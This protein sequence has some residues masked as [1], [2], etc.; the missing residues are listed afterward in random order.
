MNNNSFDFSYSY[1]QK[2]LFIIKTNFDQYL[3][4]QAPIVFRKQHNKPTIF[5]RH[6]ID[7]DLEKALVMAQI[8]YENKIKSCYMVMTNCSFY[9]LQNNSAKSI[10][11]EILKMGHEVGLHFDFANSEIRSNNSLINDSVIEQIDHDCEFLENVI[12]Q[13]VQTI[14]FHRPLQQFLRGPLIV[15]GRINAYSAELM[16]W[17]LSDSKGIWREGAPIQFLEKPKKPSLQLLVHPIWWGFNHQS[18][19]DRL[20]S[21]FEDKTKN[22]TIEEIVKFDNNLSSHLSIYRS[23]I[24]E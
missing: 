9:S 1:Y 14:S 19:N 21:F 2:I 4:S 5:L 24:G 15:A 3:F 23:K 6:D 16:E 10:L 13:K 17:Y 20:Q 12:S 7:L 18:S 11:N 8:E 22:L